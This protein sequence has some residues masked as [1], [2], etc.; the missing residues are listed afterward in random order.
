MIIKSK[1][2][3]KIK[4]SSVAEVLSNCSQVMKRGLAF[5]SPSARPLFKYCVVH[6]LKCDMTLSR[7]F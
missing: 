6:I 5:S 4:V 1:H 2:D 3:E 7:N